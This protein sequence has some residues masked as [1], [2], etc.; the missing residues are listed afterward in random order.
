MHAWQSPHFSRYGLFYSPLLCV[1]IAPCSTTCL[2]N[3]D[4]VF[5]LADLCSR[6]ATD[7][8][9]PHLKI[10]ILA[11]LTSDFHTAYVD[12]I[13]IVTSL[14]GFDLVT[15]WKKDRISIASALRGMN[16]HGRCEIVK[17]Y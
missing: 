1:N 5:V 2:H 3:T 9:P 13:D 10:Q 8:L 16:N 11:A 4:P 14:I 6:D 15:E 17:V 12:D 7:G